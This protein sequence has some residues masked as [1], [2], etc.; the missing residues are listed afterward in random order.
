MVVRGR[1]LWREGGAVSV[2]EVRD[3]GREVPRSSLLYGADYR[4]IIYFK[5]GTTYSEYLS[6]VDY[7]TN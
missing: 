3:V 2:T 6:T 1:L 4:H 7:Q 5:T